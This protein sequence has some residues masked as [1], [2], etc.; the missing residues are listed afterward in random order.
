MFSNFV[1]M[2]YFVF[3][4]FFGF[5]IPMRFTS[6]MIFSNDKGMIKL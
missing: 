6:F 2:F 5:K 4:L 1:G 3:E